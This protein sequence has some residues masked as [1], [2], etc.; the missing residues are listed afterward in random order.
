MSVYFLQIVYDNSA[1]TV[2]LITGFLIT[3][4]LFLTAC[5]HFIMIP[6]VQVFISFT[7]TVFIIAQFV[8]YFCVLC[9]ELPVFMMIVIMTRFAVWITLCRDVEMFCCELRIL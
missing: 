4:R 7:M 9:D 8:F 6:I 2:V 1:I 5:F 3:F